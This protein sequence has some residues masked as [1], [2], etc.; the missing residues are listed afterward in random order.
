MR[1]RPCAVLALTLLLAACSGSATSTDSSASPSG[2][3]S[4]A[5]TPPPT[6]GA[7]PSP[8]V[9]VK[10]LPVPKA[11]GSSGSELTVK[12]AGACYLA[13][14]TVNNQVLPPLFQLVVTSATDPAR[15]HDTARPA[16]AA[17]ATSSQVLLGRRWP[18]AVAGPIRELGQ[19][20]RDM[21][22]IAARLVAD[23]TTDQMAQDR[24]ALADAR[25]D[26]QAFCDLGSAIRAP[27]GLPPVQ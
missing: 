13:L 18:A 23:T 17:L 6:T 27:L 26:Q 21:A 3:P 1:L 7:S 9:P 5:S 20:H 11:C 4:S 12:Q 25:G 15:V 16:A 24:G 14:T 19:R 10:A 22:V 2:A 8:A